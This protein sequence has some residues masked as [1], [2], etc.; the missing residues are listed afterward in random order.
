MF[1]TR[2]VNPQISSKRHGRL[3]KIMFY[4]KVL[5]V[6]SLIAPLQLAYAQV[7][8]PCK[9]KFSGYSGICK[10]ST[11]C[12][13]VEEQAKR[14]I[15]PTICGWYELTTPIVCCEDSNSFSSQPNSLDPISFPEQPTR[16]V[17]KKPGGNKRKSE[18]KCQ[19]YSQSITST[20]QAIP[21]LTETE[22]ININI[23][24]C[25]YNSVALIVGGKPAG[26]G[27]FPFMAAIGFE[28]DN[29]ILWNCG[30]TLISDKF[31][32][33]AAHCTFSRDYGDPKVVRLG[34]LDLTRTDEGSDHVDYDISRIISHPKYVPNVNYYDIGL[35]ELNRKVKITQFI[36]PACLHSKRRIDERIAVA[37]GYGATDYTAENANKL[38][39]VSLNIYDNNLCAR[40]FNTEKKLPR[41]ITENMLCA[42]E[43][44]GNKDTC[45]GDS[46]GP[47]LVTQKDNQCKFFVVGITSFGRL[48]VLVQKIAY[49]QVGENCLIH[50]SGGIHGT[51]KYAADCPKAV[52]QAKHGIR[53]HNCGFDDLTPIICCEDDD[54]FFSKPRS[55]NEPEKRICE[56]KCHEYSKSVTKTI[57]GLSL[58]PNAENSNIEGSKCDFNKIPFI[59]GGEPAEEGE[60]PFIAALGYKIEDKIEWLCGG[61][62]ISEKFILTVAHCIY[63]SNGIPKLARLGYTN[64]KN[65]NPNIHHAEIKI[66][67]TIEH[68]K[69]DP[70]FNYNDIALLELETPIEFSKYIRPACLQPIREFNESLATAIGYGINNF[71]E[72]TK[73]DDLLKVGLHVY[74]NSVCDNVFKSDKHVPNGL[75]SFGKYCGF[76]KPAIYTRVSEYLDWIED[77]I[78]K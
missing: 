14:G 71:F 21:L 54:S 60:F 3:R 59:I 2:A 66:L 29:K 41:G 12:P 4:Y 68:Q 9:I 45:Q 74:N 48:C 49:G 27:E 67:R 53:P 22:P 8:N 50:L 75:T 70:K 23:A 16:P 31:V 33:T 77:I 56:E 34:D 38:M 24:K 7:G 42:G 17:N 1:L 72:E 73:S 47:L 62:L 15:S 65:P 63:S 78:W 40:A 19:E 13:K 46:G 6:F 36:R 57:K 5:Y 10:I 51:C 26:I 61:S 25:D 20:V 32:L 55:L 44:E 76:N 39:K 64:L 28:G 30:G 11:D 18:E 58:L 69:Y 43:L 52:E 35:L 37:T